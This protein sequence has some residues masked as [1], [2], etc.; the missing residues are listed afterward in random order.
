MTARTDRRQS[1]ASIWIETAPGNED[2]AIAALNRTM[3][4][5][6]PLVSYEPGISDVSLCGR[7]I[8][9]VSPRTPA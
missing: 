4:T 6:F 5:D 3:L 1:A 8:V 9:V 2:R 7:V